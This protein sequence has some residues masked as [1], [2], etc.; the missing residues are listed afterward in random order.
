MDASDIQEQ[1]YFEQNPMR[2]GKFWSPLPFNG[3]ESTV[4]VSERNL[5]D[6]SKSTEQN[7]LAIIGVVAI[8]I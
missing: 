6:I 1:V 8:D 3:R 4:G 5:F 2:C 7:R